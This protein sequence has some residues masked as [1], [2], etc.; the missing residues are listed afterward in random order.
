[1]GGRG[2][3]FSV[4]LRPAQFTQRVPDQ[5]GLHR[6]HDKKKNTIL[7]IYFVYMCLYL[8]VC[9]CTTGAFGDRKRGL[10]PQALVL[11]AVVSPS[12]GVGN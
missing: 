8:S 12:V 2:R 6:L 11:E 5:S 4:N 3:Q 9:M 1:M 10:D 7:N